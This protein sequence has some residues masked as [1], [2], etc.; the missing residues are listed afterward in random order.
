MFLVAFGLWNAGVLL[1]IGF[2]YSKPVFLLFLLL[3]LDFFK[4][5]FLLLFSL[6]EGQIGKKLSVHIAFQKVIW[7]PFMTKIIF[8]ILTKLQ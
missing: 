2:A 8:Q 7:V 1:K 6:F 5:N 3:T 4:S